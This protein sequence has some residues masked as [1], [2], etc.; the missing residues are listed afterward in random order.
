[1]P[2]NSQSALQGAGS[3]ASAAITHLIPAQGVGTV[4]RVMEANV[5]VIVNGSGAW[6]L[7]DTAGTPLVMH[8]GSGTI[9]G[10]TTNLEYAGG[11]GFALGTNQGLDLVGPTTG[12]AFASVSALLAR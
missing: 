10:G 11:N 1:M 5:N 7:Q 8:Q 9:A 2:Q 4:I 12:T 6:I 3:A